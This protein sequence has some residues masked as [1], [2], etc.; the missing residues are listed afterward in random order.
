MELHLLP[1]F[2]PILFLLVYLE[3]RHDNEERKVT[4]EK[5]YNLSSSI[6][7]ISFGMIERVFDVFFFLGLIFV[8]NFIESSIGLFNIQLNSVLPWI[9]CFL[10]L[11]F[12]IYWFHRSGHMINILWGAH[13]THHQCE[14]FNLTVAFRNSVF[15]HI[16][17]SVYMLILPVLGFP[18]EMIIICLTISGIWQFC[19]HTKHINRLG[20]LE[21][22]MMTPSHHRVH[23]GR[24]PL[25]IDKNFGGFLI[26]WD[27]LFGTFQEEVEEV[28]FGITEQVEHNNPLV[29]MTHVWKDIL[30]VS[31]TKKS[32]LQR[33][34]LWFQT[35]GAF[36]E[37]NMTVLDK[38]KELAFA[39]RPNKR[40]QKYQVL[41]LSV[42]AAIL[43]YFL[44]YVEYFSAIGMATCIIFIVVSVINIS[45]LPTNKDWVR[46][47]ERYRLLSFVLLPLLFKSGVLFILGGVI[48]L[49]SMRRNL[50]KELTDV[51]AF[52]TKSFQKD[53]L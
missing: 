27:K 34:K 21:R 35:P 20:F 48:V 31:S 15:P 13:V 23:H 40:V 17:R 12:V 43:L 49:C 11:D 24:N 41:H 39:K 28:Q 42:T 47:L 19:I 29:A 25:Y 51:A 26:I 16:F 50:M 46:K 6:T 22:F 5:N 4:G 33:I 14:E 37:E 10:I 45:L 44:V 18:G 38:S 7:N 32:F 9:L 52:K 2:I 8:F 53:F 30:K 1:L 36:Y 3:W